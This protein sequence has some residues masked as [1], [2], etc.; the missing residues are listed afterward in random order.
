LETRSQDRL[1]RSGLAAVATLARALRSGRSARR[2]QRERL[3]DR[4]LTRAL[5]IWMG[6]L[7]DV[8]DLLPPVAGLFDLVLVDEGS[9]TEQTIA[10][11]S[12]LR[13]RRAVVVGDPRQLR[14]V[15]FLSD[16]TIG[17]ALERHGVDP[18]D[19]SQLD[20]RRNSLFDAAAAA[21]P[22]VML[23]EHFRSAPHLIDFVARSLYGGLPYVATRTP[24]TETIDCVHVK[25]TNG[26]REQGGVVRAEIDAVVA[27]LRRLPSNVRSVGVIT[28]F[29]AQA[30]A[31]EEAILAS[32]NANDLVRMGVR[33][34]TVHSFQGNERDIVF[35]SLGIVDG[36]AN[37][38]SFASDPHL[39]AVMLTRARTSMTIISSC[40]PDAVSVLGQYVANADSPPG[41]PAPAA[42]LSSWAQS[43]VTAS[44][45]QGCSHSRLTRQDA[46][47]L[48]QPSSP[49]TSPLQSSAS[50]TRKESKPISRASSPCFARDGSRS[51]HFDPNGKTDKPNSPL[52]SPHKSAPRAE[53]GAHTALSVTG[54]ENEPRRKLPAMQA[55]IRH[56][57]VRR[58]RC[59]VLEFV[60][61]ARRIHDEIDRSR[62]VT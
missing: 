3:R 57:G 6:T 32:F 55:T 7:G 4:S 33:V 59:V 11:S 24:I 22:V 40:T 20:V 9:S 39:L 49:E 58:S 52:R 19:R 1:N 28:P 30:D 43:V 21:C 53:P 46:T 38:W 44:D 54:F 34:G 60:S 31:L 10:A 41:P 18:S 62:D 37:G 35:C 25:R 12:L 56:P 47:S 2:V 26:T 45:S 27:S 36:D 8:D 42:A 48:T 16:A 29:R 51:T 15:S 61:T 13:A 50:C 17:E 14:H 23:D 5:R